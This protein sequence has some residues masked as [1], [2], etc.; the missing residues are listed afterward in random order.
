MNSTRYKSKNEWAKELNVPYPFDSKC[1][2][3]FNEILKETDAEIVLSSDWKLYW[4]LIQ[5][6]TIFKNNGVKKSPI[7]ITTTTLVSISLTE[8]NRAHQIKDYIKRHKPKKFV[9]IEDLNIIPFMDGI[10]NHVV[11][12]CSAEGLK[13]IGI[14]SKIIS[15]LKDDSIM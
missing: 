3:I 2:K 1:V 7:D 11:R 14:K 8:K 4:T 13:E 10:K 5:L 12:T 15:I 9:I 6:D